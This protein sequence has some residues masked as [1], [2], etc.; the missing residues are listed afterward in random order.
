M[1]LVMKVV[2]AILATLAPLLAQ[3]DRFSTPACAGEGLELADR[4]VF[5]VCFDSNLK[6]PV[7]TAH[8]IKPERLHGESAR[9]RQFQHD[10][11]LSGPISRNSDYR[12]SGF[13]RGH[14]VPA[15]DMAWSDAAIRSTFLLSNAVPQRQSVNAGSWRQ[16]EAAVHRIASVSDA[17]YVF[18]G[19]IFEGD[20]ERIGD[21]AV[22][23]PTYT[24]KVVL[25]ITGKRNTM[26]AAIVP[27]G[28]T[29]GKP[30]GYFTSTVEEVELRTGLD[31]FGGLADEEESRLQASSESFPTGIRVAMKQAGAAPFDDSGRT[32]NATTSPGPAAR[33]APRRRGR[34][35]EVASRSGDAGRRSPHR[36][37]SLQFA[38]WRRRNKQDR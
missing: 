24:F 13:S 17:L 32:I 26:Y 5:L 20:I 37:C 18:T 22:A 30:L 9:P 2:V 38:T 4:A 34:T 8:E 7:W 21:G 12:G 28:P 16:L 31:F 35:S 27:N 29:G 6:V 14:M 10:L 23:V 25:A 33:S 1:F 36:F 15:E 11:G 19:P 3:P